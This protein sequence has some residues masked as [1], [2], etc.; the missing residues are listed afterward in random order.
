MAADNHLRTGLPTA[1]LTSRECFHVLPAPQMAARRTHVPVPQV[2]VIPDLAELA[3]AQALL[4]PAQV[5]VDV[6]GAARLR[7]SEWLRGRRRSCCG[8]G[9]G[10]A[11]NHD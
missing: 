2:L 4:A 9:R 5:R 1:D 8:S 11:G 7:Q 10:E 3:G 6:A